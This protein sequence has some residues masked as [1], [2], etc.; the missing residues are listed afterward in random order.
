MDEIN[1]QEEIRSKYPINTFNGTT[2]DELVEFIANLIAIK[3]LE[4]QIITLKS[5][6]DSAIGVNNIIQGTLIEEINYS[7]K[8]SEQQLLKLKEGIK[9]PNLLQKKGNE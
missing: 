4:R 5:V 7:I 3:E 2:Q 1:I 9:R 6:R 8:N